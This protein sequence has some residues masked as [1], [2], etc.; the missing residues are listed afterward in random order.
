MVV[1]LAGVTF[2]DCCGYGSLVAS[3]LAVQRS[4][5]TLTVR[6]QSGQPARLFEL[7]AGLDIAG[8]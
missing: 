6:G 3:R 7:I 4:G 8:L 1:D 2:M 5:R